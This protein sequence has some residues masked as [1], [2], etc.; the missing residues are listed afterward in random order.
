M[1]FK[2]W[3]SIVTSCPLNLSPGRVHM[4]M[5]RLIGHL[6]IKGRRCWSSC[7]LKHIFVWIYKTHF[8]WLSVEN[9]T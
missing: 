5:M 7:L 8:E 3:Q 6:I 2:C 4:I 1:F 9:K